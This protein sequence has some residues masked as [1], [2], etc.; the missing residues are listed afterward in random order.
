MLR[1]E[2]RIGEKRGIKHL[3]VRG[4]KSKL[5]LKRWSRCSGEGKD[6]LIKAGVES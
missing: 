4:E 3:K 6:K 1:K 2:G 5:G